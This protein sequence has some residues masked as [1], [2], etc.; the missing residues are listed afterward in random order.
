MELCA[1]L[2]ENNLFVITN[3]GNVTKYGKVYNV[4]G[5]IEWLITIVK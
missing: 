2:I 1:P 4:L 5:V 3:R